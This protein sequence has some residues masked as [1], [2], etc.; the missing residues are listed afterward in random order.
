MREKVQNR[1][2]FDNDV[3]PGG[4]LKVKCPEILFPPIRRNYE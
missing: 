3:I 1:E 4:A 2:K